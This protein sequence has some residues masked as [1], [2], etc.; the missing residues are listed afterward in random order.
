M[1]V[2]DMLEKSDTEIEG[3]ILKTD[4]DQRMVYGW[5]SVITEN[6]E[7]VVD[8]QSDV[9]EA[10]T[11]VKAVNKFMEN[12]RV[13]KM[14]H[15]GEQVG[16]VIHSMPITKEIGE[17]LGITSDREGWIVALKVFDDSVWSLVKSGQLKAFSIGGKA[18]R[19]V[20]DD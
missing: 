16:Q 4:D 9:I 18:K 3:Q 1:S 2:S 6:G 11:L 12:V 17:S 13:G 14:M 15:T 7:P 10:D 19:K 20:I 5:A 8:R